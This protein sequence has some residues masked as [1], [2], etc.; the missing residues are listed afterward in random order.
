M[1]ICGN[2]FDIKSDISIKE[3]SAY[4]LISLGSKTSTFDFYSEVFS[5]YNCSFS[6][7]IEAATADQII[8]LVKHGLGVGFVP[9]QFTE[10][11]ADIRT[12]SLTKPL[13]AREIV[14]VRKKEHSLPLTARKLVEL[15]KSV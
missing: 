12:I 1:P 14:L 11:D 13:P 5:K 4:P 8:P 10:E 9:R 3:L 7:D 15:M 6:P 2:D